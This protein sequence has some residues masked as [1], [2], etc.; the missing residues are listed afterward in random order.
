MEKFDRYFCSV[1]TLSFNG[2][3]SRVNCGSEPID[4][5]TPAVV[6]IAIGSTLS[7]TCSKYGYN[8]NKLASR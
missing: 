1:A 8:V 5:I 3:P 2:E 6:E 7:V 4:V